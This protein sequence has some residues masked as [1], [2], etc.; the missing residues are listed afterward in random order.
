M[1]DWCIAFE[2]DGVQSQTNNVSFVTNQDFNQVSQKTD[3]GI[4]T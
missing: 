2:T 3:F 4:Q 1:L